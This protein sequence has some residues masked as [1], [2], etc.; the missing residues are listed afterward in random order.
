[1]EASLCEE[2]SSRNNDED[3]TAQSGIAGWGERPRSKFAGG[4]SS[5]VAK[6]GLCKT[7]HE[8][9]GIG[10][11]FAQEKD[12]CVHDIDFE[13]GPAEWALLPSP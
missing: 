7:S 8:H 9:M 3:G 4:K 10:I 5:G 6:S 2:A 13:V 12:G 1:M 11:W